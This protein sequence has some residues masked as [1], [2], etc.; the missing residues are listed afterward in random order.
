M[1]VAP[2]P[3]REPGLVYAVEPGHAEGLETCHLERTPSG[4]RVIV[5]MGGV[6]Y[7]M[8]PSALVLEGILCTLRRIV[9]GELPHASLGPVG[10]RA[11]EVTSQAARVGA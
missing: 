2:L 3:V 1:I 8:E 9:R 7:V 6:V 4:P 5:S 11:L 10:H